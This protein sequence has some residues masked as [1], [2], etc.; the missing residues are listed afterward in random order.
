MLRVPAEFP[1]AGSTCF[2]TPH[3][4]EARIL[5]RN[6]NGTFLIALKRRPGDSSASDTRT[7]AAGKVH[8][9]I[10]AALGIKGKRRRAA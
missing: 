9:T 2:I 4:E 3:C 1:H 5:Q 7:L 6:A 10:E 8:A